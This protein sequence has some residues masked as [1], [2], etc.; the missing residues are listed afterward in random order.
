VWDVEVRKMQEEEEKEGLYTFSGI[1]THLSQ[2]HGWFF[3]VHF[4]TVSTDTLIDREGQRDQKKQD[5]IVMDEEIQ[6]REE[7]EEEITTD[8]NS[9]ENG[10]KKIGCR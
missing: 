4:I 2:I 10:L 6:R 5:W 7:Q 1:I 3:E 8:R 9:W